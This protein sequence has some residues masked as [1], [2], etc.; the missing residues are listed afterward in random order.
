[1]QESTPPQ[2][3][4]AVTPHTATA[5][6][7][8]PPLPQTV[9]PTHLLDRLATLF[10][11]LRL[12]VAV[13]SIV[14]VIGMLQSFSTVPRYRARATVLIQDERTTSI[15]SLN[16]NDRTYWED[17]EPY[18][19][20]QFQILKGRALG[21]RA[22]QKLDLVKK[23]LPTSNQGD[24]VS[25]VS[26]LRLKL[27][28]AVRSA[29]T[30]TPNT[31][32]PAPDENAKESATIAAFMGGVQ[33]TPIKG[34][35]L[36]EVSYDSID[37]QFATTAVNTVV[38]EYI[39]QNLDIRLRNIDSTLEWLTEQ[40]KAQQ[41]KLTAAEQAMLQYRVD[42]DAL[43]LDNRQDIVG[44]SLSAVNANLTQARATRLQKQALYE[45][46]KN[47]D[48][49]SELADSFPAVALAPSIAGLKQQMS[50]LE[51]ELAKQS[52]RGPGHPDVKTLND[53]IATLQKQLVLEK[54]RVLEAI[55]ND[56]RAA[57]ANE[58]SFAGALEDQKRRSMD[59]DRKS[60]S[61][62][63]L[64]REAAGEREV[65]QT[66]LKEE[67]ELRVIQNSRA[68]NIQLMDVAETPKAPYVP[69]RRRDVLMS[70]VFGLAL[71]VGLAFGVE[72]L[73][74]RVK[75]PD[76]VT[77]RLKLSLLGLVPAVRGERVPIL[78][79]NVPHDFGEAFR[80]LR[81]SL[82]FTSAAEGARVIGVTSTQPLEGKTTT[83]CNLGMVLAYGGARVLLIDADMRRPGLHR[84][85][86]M[87]NE[88][89]LSHVLTG[90][91]RLRQV[92]RQTSEPNLLVITAGH[93]PPNPSE[94]LA[95][96]RMQQ[97]LGHLARGPFDWVIIDTPPVLAVTDAVI[98]APHLNGF[99][100]VIGA[101]MTRIVHAERAIE[102]LKTGHQPII[103]AVLN[104]V[105]F[106][107]NKYYYSRYYGYQYKSYYG[108]S[109]T[110]V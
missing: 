97:L 1:V 27:T 106:D 43:S 108:Q 33:V 42:K 103:G 3:L 73:D 81:T 58:N 92:V 7:P 91:A 44:A 11:H 52:H 20:T 100:F 96:G 80:S 51:N 30:S 94:L 48:A 31:E 35:R 88:E 86:G 60:A 41:A 37:P 69:N 8:P 22:I 89:G 5:T 39:A 14:F 102:T 76:E 83:A 71:A 2:P 47:L 67:K 32:A 75:S 107:R 105:D 23:G 70:I 6:A 38:A 72:Y 61:Y 99:V 59:L 85:L 12:I 56:Y 64:E 9:Q 110:P 84:P 40:L 49:S 10:R 74:D 13:F 63:V 55:R 19:N 50:G 109:S 18:F 53:Q 95:S 82:V 16:A 87:T 68:N 28:D 17:P 65:Y 101:E 66:L 21:R 54:S 29:V 90:Q 77:R 93:P 62:T 57:V 15:T 46:I 104:R 24:L 4:A 25:S 34:T 98:L 26:A 36:V 78:S 79:S 45:Q